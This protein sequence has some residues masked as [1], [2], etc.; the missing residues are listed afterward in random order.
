MKKRRNF[1]FLMQNSK[2]R[3]L[4]AQ[5]PTKNKLLSDN[6]N[7]FIVQTNQQNRKFV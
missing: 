1:K 5:D 3:K 4:K 7:I 6:K 2:K